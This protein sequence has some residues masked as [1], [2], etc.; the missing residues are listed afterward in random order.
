MRRQGKE[1]GDGDAE[2]S[3]CVVDNVRADPVTR[4][5]E[6]SEREAF[7]SSKYVFAETHPQIA[8]RH[9]ACARRVAHRPN[10]PDRVEAPIHTA[11]SMSKTTRRA[12]AQPSTGKQH[13]ATAEPAPATPA[14]GFL[15]RHSS[16]IRMVLM[17]AA[18]TAAQIG[19]W[20][21]LIS[22]D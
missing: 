14:V 2:H 18:I 19:M 17:A 1:D 8:S 3:L 11:Q 10:T 15:T 13:E 21:W 9:P 22:N 16:L 4:E 5:R 6:L 20:Q 12:A 7:A